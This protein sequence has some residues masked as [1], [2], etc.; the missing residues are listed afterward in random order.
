MQ[1]V[2]YLM[3]SGALTAYRAAEFVSAL[4]G[5]FERVITVQT[6]NAKQLISPRDLTRI[7]GNHVVESYFDARILPRPQPGPVLWAPCN[8]N[9]LN[10]LAAGIADNLALSITHE[11]LGYGEPVTVA[12]SLNV[13]LFAHPV[14]RQS[15]RTLSAWGVR[16]IE[17]VETTDGLSMAT[18]DAVLKA[19]G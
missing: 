13:P 5:R 14:V 19:L 1:P 3:I 9:T 4:S 7:S 11:M 18:T 8:F 12:L 15:I 10:K 16:V 17:P 2:I 6:P